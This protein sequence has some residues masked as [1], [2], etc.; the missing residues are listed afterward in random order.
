MSSIFYSKLTSKYHEL[1]GERGRKGY[2]E[3]TSSMSCILQGREQG[4]MKQ[5][6]RKV[7]GGQVFHVGLGYA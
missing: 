2:V 1:R 5:P 6:Q 3:V 4:H 7:Q